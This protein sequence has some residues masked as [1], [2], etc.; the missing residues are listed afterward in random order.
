MAID[1]LTGKI[2]IW[3]WDINNVKGIKEIYVTWKTF[4]KML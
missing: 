4:K 3:W 2:G 1:N